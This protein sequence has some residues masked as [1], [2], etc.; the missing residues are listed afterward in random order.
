VISLNYS[1]EILFFLPL[2]NPWP[3]QLSHNLRAVEIPAVLAISVAFTEVAI[4]SEIVGTRDALWSRDHRRRRQPAA[5]K[6]QWVS[7]RRSGSEGRVN[8]SYGY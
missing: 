7:F 1:L 2:L 5:V 3:H 4:I 6:Y 8:T